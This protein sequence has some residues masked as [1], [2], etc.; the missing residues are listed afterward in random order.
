M[1]QIE[2]EKHRW[3]RYPAAVRLQKRG[4]NNFISSI[5]EPLTYK[6]IT[7][8]MKSLFDKVGFCWSVIPLRPSLCVLTFPRICGQ[9][10]RP[11]DQHSWLASF[12]NI[13]IYKV[14]FEKGKKKR[15]LR[16]SLALPSNTF[17]EDNIPNKHRPR[18]HGRVTTEIWGE[19]RMKTE[20]GVY[21]WCV[22][23]CA[24]SSKHGVLW[25]GVFGFFWSVLCALFQR[26]LLEWNHH[27]L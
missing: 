7:L 21:V 8:S 25:H 11:F 3:V 20:A 5:I 22:C 1:K 23:C 19:I 17:Q 18:E 26:S 9:P 13:L 2:Q 15:H 10:P 4:K 16:F 24:V 27:L 6:K 14:P 12:L